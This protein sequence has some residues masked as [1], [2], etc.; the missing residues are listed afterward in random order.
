MSFCQFVRKRRAIVEQRA[1]IGLLR[2]AFLMKME[3][4]HDTTLV[5]G[6]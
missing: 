2:R 4:N 6:L 5:A 1:S 3:E